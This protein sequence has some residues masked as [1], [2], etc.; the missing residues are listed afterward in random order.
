MTSSAMMSS[1]SASMPPGSTPPSVM[2]GF[3][4]VPAVVMAIIAMAYPATKTIV[5]QYGQTDL[6]GTGPDQL[7]IP[8]GFDLLLSDNSTPLHLPTG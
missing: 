8:D 5:W 4:I 2:N 6:P 7:N 3:M 1:M